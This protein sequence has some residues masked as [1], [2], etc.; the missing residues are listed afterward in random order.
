MSE[1][2]LLPETRSRHLTRATR[3]H[4]GFV[5]V[6]AVLTAGAAGLVTTA[7]VVSPRTPMSNDEVVSWIQVHD[8]SFAHMVRAL[9]HG[10]Q[11]IPPVY[12]G[13]SW[14]WVRL[15]GEGATALRL[16]S[17]GGMAAGFVFT[18]LALR[19]RLGFWSTT[20]GCSSAFFLSSLVFEHVANARPYGLMIGL[21]GAVLLH[22]E[23]FDRGSVRGWKA[24]LSGGLLHGAMALSHVYG[25]AYSGAFVCGRFVADRKQRASSPIYYGGVLL[26]WLLYLPWLGSVVRQAQQYTGKSWLGPPTFV[27]LINAVGASVRL[28]LILVL[29]FAAGLLRVGL[30]SREET[31][32]TGSEEAAAFPLLAVGLCM[33]L[34]VPLAMWL[35]SRLGVPVF[36]RRYMIP[37]IVGWSILLAWLWRQEIWGTEGELWPRKARRLARVFSAACFAALVLVPVAKAL[38][39]P[40]RRPPQLPEIIAHTGLPVAVERAHDF[41]PLVYYLGP[42]S[43]VCFILDPA[44]LSDPSSSGAAASDYHLLR[45]VKQYYPRFCIVDGNQFLK[46]HPEFVV[47]DHDNIGW[48]ERALEKAPAYSCTELAPAV[49][50]VQRRLPDGGE[51]TGAN[52]PP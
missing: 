17:A 23:A 47:L 9:A 1:T 35:E 19:R 18:W 16:L 27:T 31:V 7:V 15:V 41:L 5:P 51:E 20:L 3:P 50:L 11:V 8:P 40:H 33:V 45:C 32:T 25:A 42:R 48:S 26:G 30:A 10:L 29:L 12:P 37:G 38:G 4:R 34:L 43:D 13:M 39:A 46:A 52:A 21:S 24:L 44:V 2:S 6:L 36:N 22:Y 14:L 49:L 28:E